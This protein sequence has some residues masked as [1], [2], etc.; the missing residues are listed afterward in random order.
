M[1]NRREVVAAGVAAVSALAFGG[2]VRAAEEGGGGKPETIRLWEGDAPGAKGKEDADIPT[3]TVYRAPADKANGAAVVICPGGGYGGLAMD[4]EGHQVARWLNSI[5]VAGC[6]LKYR[7]GRRYHHPAML[8]DV[9]RA[10]RTVRAR[11]GDWKLDG[12]RVGVLGFSAGGHLASTAATHFDEGDAKAADPVDRLSS[13]PDVAVLIYPVIMLDGPHAHTGS[14]DNLLGENAPREMIDLLSN[15][16]RVTERTPPTFL[17][18]SVDD[19]PVPP[20]NSLEFARSLRAH[21]VPF[22]L[23][24]YDHGG[25]GYGLGGNDAALSTWPVVCAKWL[26]G[27][28]FLEGAGKQ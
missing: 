2:Q 17:V 9:G 23:H 21:K 25:H 6:I 14:R 22:E 5:G 3:L 7:L 8:T 27:R 11:A 13:R 16:K 4:H 24:L 1:F 20:E 19:T 15:E 10:I 18:H 26:A 28:G 12:G